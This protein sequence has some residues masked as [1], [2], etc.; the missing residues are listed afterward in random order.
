MP[1]HSTRKDVSGNYSLTQRVGD[2]FIDGINKKKKKKESCRSF[3]KQC[4]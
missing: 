3:W 4:D 1:R 2:L